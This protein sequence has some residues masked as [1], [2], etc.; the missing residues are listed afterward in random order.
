MF[1]SY[2]TIAFRNLA[3]QRTLTFINIIG[4]SVGIACFYLFVLYGVNEFSFDRSIANH[5]N[6]YRVYRWQEANGE[7][8]A[9]GNA[10]QPHLTYSKI[11]INATLSKTL[12]RAL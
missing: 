5:Q 2:F 10:L 3:K 11:S 4:L 1:K 12:S 9:H 6:I 8:K 7:E